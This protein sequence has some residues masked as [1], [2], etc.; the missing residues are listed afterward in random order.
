MN[1]N[2]NILKVSIPF[3]LI[4]TFIYPIKPFFAPNINFF[5]L[6][7]FT[8]LYI[9]FN[10]K[11]T[12]RLV[13][14]KDIIITVVVFLILV[15]L[16][17][18]SMLINSNFEFVYIGISIK[19]LF[20][21]LMAI[22][23]ISFI[24]EKGFSEEKLI[25]YFIYFSLLLAFSCILEFFI[26]PIKKILAF[27]FISTDNIHYDRSF[28]VKGFV[29][30]GG[31]TLSFILSISLM[32]SHGLFLKKKNILYIIVALILTIGIIFVGRT[33]I[34]LASISWFIFFLLF[35]FLSNAKNIIYLILIS[36]I[37]I[38]TMDFLMLSEEENDIIFKY[39]FEIFT[40]YFEKGK[41]ESGSTTAVMNM[42]FIPDLK[43]FIFG[44]GLYKAYKTYQP[45]DIGYIKQ[46][47][48]TGIFGSI[49]FYVLMIYVQFKAY[50]Y[51]KDIIGIPF[52]I[53]ILC[54]FWIVEG[55]EPVFIQSYACR[56]LLLMFIYSLF[57]KE[58]KMI[59]DT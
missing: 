58:P 21:M 31:A 3:F 19:Y 57:R 22:C 27:V 16:N 48:S 56:L 36:I 41:L 45:T 39:S 40:N 25:K 17:T 6:I 24:T 33:G 15:M 20:T 42:Y 30:G 1:I 2:L 34:V 13:N 4:T 8:F 18:M 54:T 49:L 35:L 32:M 47:L 37:I 46:L 50:H 51:F 43:H 23:I 9:F 11:E 29:S 12:Y 26:P 28:R 7:L 55:K 44:E 14:N 10:P 38:F 52:M 5:L 53:L 59:R